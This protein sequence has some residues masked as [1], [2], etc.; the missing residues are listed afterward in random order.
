MLFLTGYSFLQK[1]VEDMEGNHDS[2]KVAEEPQSVLAQ[3]EWRCLDG[4]PQ[5]RKTVL[6][7]IQCL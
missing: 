1:S 6:C 4:S 3:T 7:G 2:R 5:Q